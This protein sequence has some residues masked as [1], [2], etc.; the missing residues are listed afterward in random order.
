M[1][2][3]FKIKLKSY[4]KKMLICGLMDNLTKQ[5]TKNEWNFFKNLLQM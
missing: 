5:M 4:V 2:G 3:F 1:K